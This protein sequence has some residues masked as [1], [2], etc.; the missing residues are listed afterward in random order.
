MSQLSR[1]ALNASPAGTV[2]LDRTYTPPSGSG[3]GEPNP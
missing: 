2:N 3:K 1:D